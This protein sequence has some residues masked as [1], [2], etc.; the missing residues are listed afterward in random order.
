M[1][2]SLRITT[3]ASEI[4]NSKDQVALVD[5]VSYLSIL[6]IKLKDPEITNIIKMI[7]ETLEEAGS[8]I[9]VLQEEMNVVDHCAEGSAN[10]R[11][12]A[13]KR[14]KERGNK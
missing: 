4:L 6:N 9:K 12:L 11:E 14:Q 1:E 7:Q 5:P 10:S 13:K 3:R 8:L 2:Q